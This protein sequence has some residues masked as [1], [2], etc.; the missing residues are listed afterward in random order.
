MNPAPPVTRILLPAI[1]LTFAPLSTTVQASSFMI[2]S[3][4]IY[5]STT[6]GIYF[7]GEGICNYCR[8]VDS[9]IEI[10][11][12][13]SPRGELLFR[14]LVERIKRTQ[15]RSAYDCVIGVSGGTDSS[16][17]LLLAKE[18]G[19]RPLAVHYDNTWN[20]AVATQNIAIVTKK[21]G[22]DLVT[23]VIDNKEQDR[24]KLAL[25]RAGV[26]EFDADT[27]IAFISVLRRVAA[28]HRIKYIF[29]GHSFL[30]EGISPIGSNY[31]DNA[32]VFDICRRY[33]GFRPKTYPSMG[34]WT[35]LKWSVIYR[36]QIIRPLWYLK[37]D[38][39]KA[40]ERLQSEF[41]WRNYGGHHL[42]NRAS[43]FVHTVWLPQRFKI[44]FRNLTL[45]ANA[46]R[47]AQ[48]REDALSRYR[49]P[50]IVDK[51]LIRYVQKRLDLTNESYADLMSGP[52]RDWREFKTYKRR[53][54]LMRPVFYLLAK[55]QL[56]PMS[57]YLKYCFPMK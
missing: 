44:D 37:Y 53:F 49:S 54:E 13:E 30:T 50:I 16:Y 47:G 15:K 35:F 21:L 46:R 39:A 17:L 52:R 9:L 5:D 57:F 33:G 32:Y 22:I 6:N 31:F 23:Y 36:Q 34:F 1:R 10:Y 8:Q 41:G 4:C 27:D 24:M 29:E 2:C 45:A 56:V 28:K 25:M 18:M 12:T 19:L 14:Q 42:E 3:R 26:P 51:N 38:K 43:A 7:D 55:S 40:Q 11:G 20:S 48:T